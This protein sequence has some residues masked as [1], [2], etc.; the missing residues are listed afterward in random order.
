MLHLRPAF[1]SSVALEYE[2]SMTPPMT[3]D[4]LRTPED[5]SSHDVVS[6]VGDG[7]YA[8]AARACRMFGTTAADLEAPVVVSSQH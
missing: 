5:E 1:L 4:S 8:V 2:R 3:W 6:P 7:G